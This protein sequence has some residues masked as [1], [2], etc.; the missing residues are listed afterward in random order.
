M[1][2]LENDPLYLEIVRRV[3][4]GEWTPHRVDE[5]YPTR[6]APEVRYRGGA[7]DGDKQA[8]LWE[9]Y[10]AADENRP[11]QP[12]AADAIRKL[13]LGVFG[14]RVEDWNKEFGTPLAKKSL[15]KGAK[16]KGVY[17]RT[18]QRRADTM[19]PLW[20]YGRELIANGRKVDDDFYNELGEKFGIK[21]AD[22]VRKYYWQPM[23]RLMKE[24]GAKFPA[25]MFR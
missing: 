15:K 17:A 8:L 19:V 23:Q 1:S 13:M 3:A 12:W 24:L 2:A 10:L 21:S 6:G 7:R 18:Q 16:S 25:E 9:A 14:G 20:R 5:R 11:L 22:D 4:R